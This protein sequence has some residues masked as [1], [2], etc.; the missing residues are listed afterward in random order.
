MNV[1]FGSKE[2]RKTF[3]GKKSFV[4][5]NLKIQKWFSSKLKIS[6]VVILDSREVS[7]FWIF[8]LGD[9]FACAQRTY[10]VYQGSVQ[11]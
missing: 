5:F 6:F 7:I 10:I 11:A 4:K 9:F 8:K 2:R 1:K 3:E